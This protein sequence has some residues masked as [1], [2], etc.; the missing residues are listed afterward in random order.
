VIPHLAPHNTHSLIP[1][2][3]NKLNLIGSGEDLPVSLASLLVV[4]LLGAPTH[5]D[6]HDVFVQL[7]GTI[8]LNYSDAISGRVVST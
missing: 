5:L 7:R 1:P 2:D 8:P 6:G 3:L 4:H